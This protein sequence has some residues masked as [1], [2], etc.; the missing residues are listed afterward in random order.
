MKDGGQDE[1]PLAPVGLSSANLPERSRRHSQARYL[2]FCLRT[3]GCASSL[4][5][6]D[7][8]ASF[9]SV[10]VRLH[11]PFSQKHP[12][13]RSDTLTESDRPDADRHSSPP[14]PSTCTVL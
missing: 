5:E 13:V 14:P 4:Y 7:T 8:S 1:R 3:D 2:L 6:F 9:L 11:P 12:T 10:A